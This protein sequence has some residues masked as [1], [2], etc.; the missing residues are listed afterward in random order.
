M[1]PALP[2]TLKTDVFPTVLY[3]TSLKKEDIDN[4]TTQIS[5]LSLCCKDQKWYLCY[6]LQFYYLEMFDW[7]SWPKAFSTNSVMCCDVALLLNSISF[8]RP[9]ASSVLSVA[10]LGTRLLESSDLRSI[11]VLERFLALGFRPS[12][13]DILIREFLRPPH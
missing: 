11:K 4:N 2:A 12:L 3:N 8:I 7:L 1:F 5:G 6:T 9:L 13:S 10:D